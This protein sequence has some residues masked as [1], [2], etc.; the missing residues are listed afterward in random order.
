MKFFQKAHFLILGP[1]PVA[2]ELVANVRY[3]RP[4]GVCTGQGVLV[5]TLSLPSLGFLGEGE[6]RTSIQWEK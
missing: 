4:V 3:S 2:V 5:H 6:A 1:L